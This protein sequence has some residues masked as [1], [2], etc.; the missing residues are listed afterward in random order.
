MTFQNGDF[1][2]VIEGLIV[3]DCNNLEVHVLDERGRRVGEF[4]HLVIRSSERQHF[5]SDMHAQS[6][7]TIGVG[8]AREYFEFARNK[9][10]V[11]IAG[12]QGNDFQITDAFGNI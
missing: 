9:A 2:K 7:E 8:T 11:D 1:C 6:G 10:F 3:S 5:W 12:H 4:K